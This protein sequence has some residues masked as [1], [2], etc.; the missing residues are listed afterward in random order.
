[1]VRN[2]TGGTTQAGAGPGG[3]NRLLMGVGFVRELVR[4]K[5]AR[6]ARAREIERVSEKARASGRE[7]S[8]TGRLKR[9]ERERGRGLS[10]E[11]VM[12]YGSNGF[13]HSM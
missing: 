11:K 5:Y 9:L 8:A 2:L 6:D 1:M 7:G 4:R 12:Y 3:R 10:G 13:G